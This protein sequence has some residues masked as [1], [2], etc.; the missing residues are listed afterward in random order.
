MGQQQQQGDTGLLQADGNEHQTQV[1]GGSVAE[2]T[3]EV[4]LGQGHQAT[5]QG[6]DGADREQHLGRQR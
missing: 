2:R 6:A 1:G 3:L 5:S 4:D